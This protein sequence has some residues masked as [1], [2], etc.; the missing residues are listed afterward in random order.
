MTTRIT[1]AEN[2]KRA[3]G[4]FILCPVDEDYGWNSADEENT[5]IIQREDFPAL[6]RGLGWNGEDD[7]IEAA[8]HIIRD[9]GIGEFFED[10]EYFE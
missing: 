5:I 4:C 3:P 8:E 1:I 9:I 7:N 6:A 10:T 2:T